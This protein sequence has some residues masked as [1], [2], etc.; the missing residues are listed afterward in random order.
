MV[1]LNLRQKYEVYNTLTEDERIYLREVVH[2]IMCH[3]ADIQEYLEVSLL[4]KRS[5]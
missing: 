1:V 4:A 5:S 2:Q 3:K